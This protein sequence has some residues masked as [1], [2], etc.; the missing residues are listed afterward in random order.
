MKKLLK[1]SRATVCLLVYGLAIP[2]C[3]CAQIYTID[4]NSTVGPGSYTFNLQDLKAD[5]SSPS[6]SQYLDPNGSVQ[7]NDN[8]ASGVFLDVSSGSQMEFDVSDYNYRV[9]LYAYAPPGLISGTSVSDLMTCLDNF[10]QT[11]SSGIQEYLGSG[12][13]AFGDVTSYSITTVSE[14]SDLSFLG[15]SLVCIGWLWRRPTALRNQPN[16]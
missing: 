2:F 7:F 4:F 8:F 14:P 12:A 1:T 16:A 3:V 10:D 11:T 5:Y 9:E 6:Q 15:I 13:Y